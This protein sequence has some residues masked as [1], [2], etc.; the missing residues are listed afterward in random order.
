MVGLY[1]GEPLRPGYERMTSQRPSARPPRPSLA[2]VGGAER[3]VVGLSV[4]QNVTPRAEPP[5][6]G[7]LRYLVKHLI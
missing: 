2:H 7:A 4:T 1:G 3:L 6:R 5:I